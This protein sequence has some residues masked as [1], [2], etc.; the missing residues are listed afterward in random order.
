MTEDAHTPTG[1]CVEPRE[2]GD[3]GGD[4]ISV[5][6]ISGAQGTAIG[7]NASATVVGSSVEA[8]AKID[9]R[10]LRAALEELWQALDNSSLPGE[11]KRRTS[12]AASNAIDGVEPD[13]V[14]DDGV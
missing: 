2:S 13:R 8:G 7:R 12:A 1:R 10:E 3:V 5:G 9:A 11:S 4:Q 14:D 6:D